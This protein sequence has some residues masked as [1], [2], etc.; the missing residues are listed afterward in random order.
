MQNFIDSHVVLPLKNAIEADDV[1]D[2]NGC[3]IREIS[4]IQGHF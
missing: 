3:K 4:L 1:F 2:N